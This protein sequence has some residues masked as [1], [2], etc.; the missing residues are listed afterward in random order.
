M[1]WPIFQNQHCKIEGKWTIHSLLYTLNIFVVKWSKWWRCHCLNILWQSRCR[2]YGMGFFYQIYWKL[3]QKQSHKY[4]S[5]LHNFEKTRYIANSKWDCTW[6]HNLESICFSNVR[7][8]VFFFSSSFFFS[9]HD[10]FVALESSKCLMF[11]T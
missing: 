9:L 10:S 6:W 5:F 1:T 4:Q 7:R 3:A 2:W 11:Q 8:G